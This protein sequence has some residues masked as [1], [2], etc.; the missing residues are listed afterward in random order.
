MYMNIFTYYTYIS[1]SIYLSI[2]IYIYI[3]LS[4]YIYIYI[5]IYM[6]EI[7]PKLQLP[8]SSAH[9]VPPRGD[10]QRDRQRWRAEADEEVEIES[11]SIFS[12]KF[13]NL[14]STL[15][16]PVVSSTGAHGFVRIS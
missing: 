12:A 2:Y 13:T 4:L 7:A 11:P 15:G 10:A 8:P 1:I 3:S 6:Y 16:G 9:R 14:S 5:Y